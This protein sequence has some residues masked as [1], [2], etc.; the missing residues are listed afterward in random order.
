MAEQ[1]EDAQKTEEPTPKKLEDARQKGQI[2]SSREV[3]HWFLLLAGA[4]SFMVLAPGL[5]GDIVRALA[6][7]VTEPDRMVVDQAGVGQAL[8]Q[9]LGDVV[10]AMLPFLLLLM[11]AAILAGVL[12]SGLVVSLNRIKPELSKISILKGVKRLFSLKSTAE[13]VKGILKLTVV[14]AVVT[15]LFLP[16]FDQLPII[17]TLPISGVMTMLQSLAVRLFIGVLAVMTVIAVIDFLYQRFEHMK[18]M[19][20]SRQEIKDELKQSEG[21]PQ[22][23]ARLR[24]IRTERARR[25]MMASVPEADVVI[26]NPTHFAVALKYNPQEMP[27]PRLIA[28]GVDAVAERI[29]DMAR[30][31]DVPLVENPPL[32]RALFAS[33]EL[34]DEIPAEHYKAVAEII[35]YVFRLKGRKMPA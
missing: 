18:S 27:A 34:E 22:V 12:Q 25:R 1:T 24:Q 6:R 4:V 2:A 10:L 17:T 29:R 13:F 3:N 19:R 28:K 5:T 31:H 23:K 15:M 16:I 9:V 14:G 7:F 8:T 20:M 21:D 26:T 35:S 33:V 30:E 11:A 32:A